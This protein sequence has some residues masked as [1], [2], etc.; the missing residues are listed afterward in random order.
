MSREIGA[1]NGPQ[2][3]IAAADSRYAT[4]ATGMSSANHRSRC[5]STMSVT[6]RLSA[7]SAAVMIANMCGSS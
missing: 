1:S 7:A 5:A 3:A 2:N 4:N 6:R